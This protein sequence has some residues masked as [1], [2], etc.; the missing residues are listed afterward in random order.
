MM[1][2]RRTLC[3]LFRMA[4]I[5]GVMAWPVA[6]EEL[7]LKNGQKIVGK[8]VG[9]ENDMFR[10]ETDYGIALVRK[11][12]V[13]SIQVAPSDAEP[14]KPTK[15]QPAAVKPEVSKPEKAVEPRLTLP[16]A[17]S[18]PLTTI[19][20]KP[21]AQS[22]AHGT[23]AAN[24]PKADSSPKPE[25]KKSESQEAHRVSARSTGSAVPVKPAT[26]GAELTSLPEKEAR[27]VTQISPKEMTRI[28]ANKVAPASGPSVKISNPSPASA[29][30]VTATKS[31]GSKKQEAK[32]SAATTIADA[33]SSA[34]IPTPLVSPQEKKESSTAL[35]GNSVKPASVPAPVK[36]LPPPP[37][38][39]HILDEP[40]PA[41][42][43][44]HVEGNTYVNDTFHFQM[45]K[46]PGWKI[47]EN[48]PGE[49][50]SGIMAMGTEDEQSL[51]IIGRQ[52][53]SGVP[54]LRN[55][56]MESRLRSNYQGY[57]KLSEESTQCGGHPAIRRTFK[58]VL[59]GAEWHGVVVHVAQG[60]T[61]FGIIGLT[62]AEM[63]EFQQA[64]LAKIISSF[65]FSPI[66][67]ISGAIPR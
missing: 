28:D 66:P 31:E 67:R 45:F 30:P 17:P 6:A 64:V 36:T 49:T 53:W 11:D 55:D 58:G 34:K 50:D 27:K 23:V 60:N 44:E 24:A 29:K 61:V 4:L 56:Q 12:K 63:Y 20:A 22:V 42:V 5:L 54:D 46:P 48:V 8:I 43:Q 41:H 3:I 62:S 2:L 14:Q 1:F 52:T 21:I 40:L 57:Q 7:V 32:F 35:F 51:L 15:V 37:P 33:P 26:S 38:A 59:D 9:Y 25:V 39:S 18:G 47:F 13:V 65:Q 10:V 16:L 19:Q